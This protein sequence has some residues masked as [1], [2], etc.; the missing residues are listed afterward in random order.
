VQVLQLPHAG[1][2]PK[3]RGNCCSICAICGQVH[4]KVDQLIQDKVLKLWAKSEN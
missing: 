4:L 3:Q 1:Y 2:G